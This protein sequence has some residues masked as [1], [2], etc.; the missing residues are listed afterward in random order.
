MTKADVHSVFSVLLN[1]DMKKHT[2]FPRAWFGFTVLINRC[3]NRRAQTPTWREDDRPCLS[4][5]AKL[6]TTIATC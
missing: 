6:M 4:H 3:Q 2:N 5:W 1:K